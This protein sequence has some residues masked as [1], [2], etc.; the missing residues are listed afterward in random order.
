VV[1]WDD[2][3]GAGGEIEKG[4]EPMRWIRERGWEIKEDEES[5]TDGKKFSVSAPRYLKEFAIGHRPEK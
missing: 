5:H 1:S 3:Q 2:R 4:R